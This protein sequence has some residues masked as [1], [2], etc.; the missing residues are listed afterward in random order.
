MR[1]RVGGEDLRA[2]VECVAQVVCAAEVKVARRRVEQARDAHGL[3]GV[4]VA[5]AEAATAVS[6]PRLLLVARGVGDLVG[7]ECERVLVL[8][9][10]VAV[11]A[12]VG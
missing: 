1:G 3:Y 5:R 7:E 11:L 4:E 9:E 10:R 6:E 2:A 8:G 12:S